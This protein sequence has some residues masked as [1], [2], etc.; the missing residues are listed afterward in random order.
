MAPSY[1][2][3]AFS[4]Y[5]DAIVLEQV[6]VRYGDWDAGKI[7][8][9]ERPTGPK[10]QL[11]FFYAD[12]RQAITHNYEKFH[13]DNVRRLVD[14]TDGDSFEAAKAAVLRA[15]TDSIASSARSRGEPPKLF[16]SRVERKGLV[17]FDEGTFQPSKYREMEM[18]DTSDDLVLNPAFG[19][20]MAAIDELIK[21]AFHNPQMR[22]ELL[23][24]IGQHKPALSDVA[25]TGDRR[26]RMLSLQQQADNLCTK[27]RE[28]RDRYESYLYQ[29]IGR[30]VDF[31]ET[32]TTKEVGGFYTVKVRY[33]V[34]PDSTEPMAPRLYLELKVKP[35][36]SEYGE[37]FSVDVNAGFRNAI[38]MVHSKFSQS[39]FD[40]SKLSDPTS[41]F[42][43]IEY[44]EGDFLKAR[45]LVRPF[46]DNESP[47]EKMSRIARRVAQKAMVIYG[48]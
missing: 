24:L 23:P 17:Y 19:G 21:I 30:K 38:D 10:D 13:T 44:L 14:V 7:L 27:L 35:D 31:E 20:K 25:L 12:F 3:Y 47:S 42:E 29:A 40:V 11:R 33:F 16:Q 28:Y 41:V 22:G 26:K 34:Q 2:N 8:I 48:E 43:W 45:R 36:D 46:V 32:H 39:G 6:R 18:S 1:E 4:E 9:E 15:I 37:G 5:S